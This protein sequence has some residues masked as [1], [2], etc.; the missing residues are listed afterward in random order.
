MEKL[1]PGASASFAVTLAVPIKA[2][3]N[4]VW[5][6]EDTTDWSRPLEAFFKRQ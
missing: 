2:I 3:T 5:L 4:G 1:Y 6:V